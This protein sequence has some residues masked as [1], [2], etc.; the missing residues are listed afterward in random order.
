MELDIYLRNT[1][2][3]STKEALVV[4]PM[5]SEGTVLAFLNR[6][7]L[8]SMQ[9]DHQ[10]EV[11]L[12]SRL[13]YRDGGSRNLTSL[14]GA[15]FFKRRGKT[16]QSLQ[17][18][19]FSSNRTRHLGQLPLSKRRNVTFFLADVN[20]QLKNKND[21][22][23]IKVDTYSNTLL[24][25]KS[26]MFIKLFTTITVYQA[27]L[28]LKVIFNFRV[29]DQRPGKLKHGLSA[30]PIVNLSC[31]IGTTILAL[32]TDL[33]F[34]TKTENFIKCNAGLSFSNADLIA[35]LTLY[36]VQSAHVG[37]LIQ[38]AQNPRQLGHLLAK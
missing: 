38:E 21:T 14:P 12:I 11:E 35:S 9:S 31:V 24:L 29:P 6:S 25:L 4:A 22:T 19:R 33:S 7:S 15:T 18:R 20:T 28:G 2:G 30:N 16:P 3:M 26:C 17:E 27:A 13:K 5:M 23:D 36:V 10:K 37:S 8:D 1:R 32:N 34:D